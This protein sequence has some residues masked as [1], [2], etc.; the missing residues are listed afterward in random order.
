[1]RKKITIGY[2]WLS[3]VLMSCMLACSKSNPDITPPGQE[4]EQGEASA[5][6]DLTSFTF[7]KALNPGLWNDIETVIENDTVYAHTLVG[8]DLSGLIPVF[9]SEGA[10]VSVDGV[11][12]ASGKS[13][14]DFTGLV[15]YTVTAENGDPHTYVIK[16]EDTGL[17]AVYLNTNGQP[18]N[19]KDDYVD[20]DI[21]ITTGL[22]GDVVFEGVMRVK[23]RGNATWG[24]PKKPYRIKLDEKAS[25]LDM[26]A[27]KN[28]VLLANYGDQSLL[29]NDLAFEVSRRVG[30]EYTPRLQYVEVFLNGEYMGNYTLGD[31]IKESKDRVPI[32]EDNGGFIIE[33]DGYASQ[34]PSHFYTPKGMPIT[35]KFPDEDDITTEEFNYI[36]DYVNTFEASLFSSRGTP[37]GDYQRYFDLKSFVDYYLINEVCSNPDMLWSMRMYKKSSQDPK[38][39]VGPVWDFDLGFNNDVRIGREDAQEKLMLDYAHDP[40]AWMNEIKQDPAF[41]QLVRSRW[42]EVKASLQSMPEYLD[43]RND[44]IQYSQI[45]NFIRWQVLGVNINQSWYTASTHQE[46]VGFVRNFLV[47]RLSWLDG[48][49]NGPAF[50]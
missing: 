6:N 47:R 18:I 25:V 46:Y 32:D 17:P 9:L 13:R 16:F 45:P 7:T 20:G 44:L 12:Q 48:V 21:K 26:P 40:R 10:T 36:R 39:Y 28:W 15:K 24:M 27:D 38:I 4:E 14:Q 23:G 19:S 22:E 50:D 1:M 34:E 11:E 49:F 29:R 33:E 37:E 41:K 3:L 2:V 8:T 5:S 42:N 43:Q 35:V 30:L 31:H